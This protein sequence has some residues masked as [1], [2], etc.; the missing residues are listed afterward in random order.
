MNSL[1]KNSVFNFFSQAGLFLSGSVL[2]I[3]LARFLGPEQMGQYSYWIWVIAA[4]GLLMTLGIPQSLTK[5]IPQYYSGRK[6]LAARIISRAF[7]TQFKLLLIPALI[8]IFALIIFGGTLE[9]T[10]LIILATIIVYSLNALLG[11]IT[12]GLQKFNSVMRINLAVSFVSPALFLIILLYFRDLNNLLLA[13]LAVSVFTFAGLFFICRTYLNFKLKK[14]PE[15]LYTEIRKY[16]ASVSFIVFLDLILME[17]SE[18]FFLRFFSTLDQI[19][20]YSIGFGLVSKVML[21]VPGAVSG[22][23]MP[24]IAWLHGK[25]DKEG[26]EGAYFSSSR[27]LMF[28]TFPVIFAG[29]LMVDIPVK[30]FYGSSYDPAIPVIKV[31]LFSG[32]LSAIAAAGSSFLYGTGKQGF[33]LK[34]ALFAV[35]VN[36]LLDIL[37]IPRLGALGASYANFTAQVSGVFIGLIY[38]VGNKKMRFPWKDGFKILM[39]ALAPLPIVFFVRMFFSDFIKPDTAGLFFQFCLLGFIY[40]VLYTLLLRSFRFFNRHDEEIV[41][42]IFKK[43]AFKL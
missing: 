33:I 17:R 31:L 22:I 26:I 8:S 2:S 39:G 32:G 42:R 19:A 15:N 4:A 36:L 40:I 25:K 7:I 30:L 37:L 43:T 9:K 27:Y 18:V 6:D 23:I 3:F 20:F 12:S 5:F 29:L 1:F 13:N 16:A 11:G 21:L 35:S 10:Y 34:L 38:I 41:M 28:I 24:K 14:L